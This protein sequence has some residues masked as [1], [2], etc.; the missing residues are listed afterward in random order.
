MQI[1][2][3]YGL[4]SAFESAAISAKKVDDRLVE[5]DNGMTV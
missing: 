3:F 4:A 5:N 2:V 1:H